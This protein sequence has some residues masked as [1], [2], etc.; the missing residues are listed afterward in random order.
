M[1]RKLVISFSII[2]I[3]LISVII[4]FYKKSEKDKDYDLLSTTEYKFW[5]LSVNGKEGVIRKDGEVILEPEFDSV[6][7]PNQD[8]PIFII[9]KD[10]KDEVYNDSK[11][12]ILTNYEDIEAIT[13]TKEDG[14]VEINNSVLKYKEN[15]LY[16]LVSFEGEKITKAIYEEIDSMP[17][18]YGAIKVKRDGKYGAINIKGK[19]LIKEKYDEIKGDGFYKDGSYK[20]AGYI[21]GN[22]TDE[23]MRYGYLNSNGKTIVKIEQEEIYRVLEISDEEEYIIAS[24]NGRYCIYK[25][26]ES[27]IDY[28]YISIDYNKDSETFTVKKNQSYGLLNKDAKE[29]IKPEYEEL[30]VAGE[31]VNVS[32]N[33]ETSTFDL[34]GKKVEEPQ[35][36]NLEKTKTEKYYIVM[37]KDYKYG[38]ID[39]NKE[40]VIE[41]KYD[42]INQIEDTDLILA[43]V[44]K[45]IIIY[46][47]NVREIVSAENANMDIVN[48]YI[49]L[50]TENNISYLTLEGKEVDNKTVY[51]NNEIY[52]QNKNGKWGFV[53]VLDEQVLD[54]IY[55][56]VTEVNEY[57][58]AGIKKDGKW[59]V[60]NSRG[61]IILEPTYESDISNPIFIGRYYKNGNRLQDSM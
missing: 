20:S 6:Q 21:V 35:Y 42:Y 57:G 32:K 46:S 14:T 28:M 17:D 58:F 51:L 23:G 41:P 45:N 11:E 40:T 3:I 2:L 25:G 61:D 37:T 31:Y 38:I 39:K 18:K 1:K 22:K 7:I 33:G 44:G 5:N 43:S 60:I 27:L 50:T 59:G 48:G 34:T 47:A 13:I 54:N 36:M 10:G 29:I 49:K 16:G 26:K 4:Y 56:E 15:G 8:I 24:Q 30:I 53:N 19:I 12:K 9:K 55:D 52:A